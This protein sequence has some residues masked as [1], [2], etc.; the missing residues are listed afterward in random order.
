L[1]FR[2][3]ILINQI[4]IRSL[5]IIQK[6]KVNKHNHME[7]DQNLTVISLMQDIKVCG[8][9]V[10]QQEYFKINHKHQYIHLIKL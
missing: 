1:S 3:N 8:I 10:L 2:K 4:F 7:T 6:I 9:K 5:Q